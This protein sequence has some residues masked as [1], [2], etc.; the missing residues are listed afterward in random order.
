[1]DKPICCSNC[2]IVPL[3][4]NLFF[5]ERWI[6][7]YE[8]GCGV[9]SILLEK[10][11]KFFS[12]AN[13][14]NLQSQNKCLYHKIDIKKYCKDCRTFLCPKCIQAHWN[15][16]IDGISYLLFR[17]SNYNK[18]KSKFSF[19]TQS[20]TSNMNKEKD[21]MMTVLTNKIEELEKDKEKLIQSYEKNRQI[22]HQLTTLVQCLFDN[23]EISKRKHLHYINLK[24]IGKFNLL[25][26]EEQEEQEEQEE[27]NDY[28]DDSYD[29]ENE[30]YVD[31][32]LGSRPVESKGAKLKRQ[33]QKLD[34]SVH[35]Q[36]QQFIDKCQNTFILIN[37]NSHL[38]GHKF[39][40]QQSFGDL[41]HYIKDEI[42]FITDK[43]LLEKRGI[44]NVTNALAIDEKRFAIIDPT[45]MS[46]LIINSESKYIEKELRFIE[47]YCSTINLTQLIVKLDNSKCLLFNGSQT[48]YLYINNGRCN[49]KQIHNINSFFY[50]ALLLKNKNLALSSSEGILYIYDFKSHYKKIIK[51]IDHSYT[52]TAI[53]ECGHNNLILIAQEYIAFYDTKTYKELHEYDFYGGPL[54]IIK[55]VGKNKFIR[56]PKGAEFYMTTLYLYNCCPFQ[57]ETTIVLQD[58]G[59]K[60]CNFYDIDGSIILTLNN[61]IY[62]MDKEKF[63]KRKLFIVSNFYTI[64]CITP[65]PNRKLAIIGGDGIIY[66]NY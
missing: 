16:K 37:E 60:Y 28:E 22:N 54:D 19:A 11:M 2:H 38:T 61:V 18:I 42:T 15:H 12:V 30:A 7:Q 57:H 10:F 40:T 66:Y 36:C 62:S 14:L 63:E 41:K 8:C 24:N 20:I 55:M 31:D 50:F 48:G 3:I 51:K 21:K 46:V 65:L 44:K 39:L 9:Y 23:Y 64:D 29:P 56:F 53:L 43:R 33:K 27:A 26:K 17:D 58:G 35:Q 49:F 5:N 6:V 59:I 52:V 13:D 4:K 25:Y 47:D 1:M 32:D 34:L 45:T